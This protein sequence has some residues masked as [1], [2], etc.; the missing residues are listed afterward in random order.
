MTEADVANLVAF[1]SSLNDVSDE[2]FRESI[3][4][5]KVFDAMS[6]VGGDR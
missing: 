4:N 5:A 3:I 1:L 6:D 2:Q